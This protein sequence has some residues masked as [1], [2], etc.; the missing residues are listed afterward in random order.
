[1]S[2]AGA[3]KSERLINLTM[4]LLASKRFLT[5]GEIFELV[6]GYSGS[7]ETK[8]RM[9]ER[10]KNDLRDLGLSIEVGTDDP[11]F[12]D[13]AG[14]RINPTSYGLASH[15]LG[16]LDATDIALLSLAATHWQNS[17]FARSGQSALRKIE[18]I[19]PMSGEES[20]SL[21]LY[22][23]E[24]PEGRFE[25][26]WEAITSQC[27]VTFTYRSMKD[28]RRTVAPIRLTFSQG[29]W[30]LT[31]LD[32]DIKEIRLFKV[33]RIENDLEISSTLDKRIFSSEYLSDLSKGNPSEISALTATLLLR[34]G[35]AHELRHISHIQPH[36]SDWDKAVAQF[37]NEEDLFES[38]ARA[39]SSAIIL[40]PL[41]T[42]ERFI[43]WVE[44]KLNV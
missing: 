11:L 33:V 12:E 41:E 19:L 16:D 17:V 20:I 3:Q 13:E 5:K 44:R 6:A 34:I 15:E 35:R 39:G 4:A 42:R 2:G 18:S 43:A 32:L 23:Q 36:D 38:L 40:S 8:E 29:F 7:P 31:A 9:F 22:S 27:A 26:L 14:Y 1:M 28:T 24:I 21:P 10:D 37:D 25:V 30:Y